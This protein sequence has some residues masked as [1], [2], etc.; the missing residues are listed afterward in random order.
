MSV[1]TFETIANKLITPDMD[2]ELAMNALIGLRA[3]HQEPWRGYHTFEHPL[4]LFDLLDEFGDEVE[5]KL[6]VGW[7]FMY[8]DAVYDP[9]LAPGKGMSEE[10]SAQ[11]S[12]SEIPTFA[13]EALANKVASL[14]RA[15][16]NHRV[17]PDDYDANFF[18]DA[19]VAILGSTPE[20]YDTYVKGIEFE[21]FRDNDETYTL[22]ERLIGRMVI[23]IDLSAR[24]DNR[25]LF[26]TDVFRE[27]F[28]AQAQENI[29]RELATLKD[30]AEY[31]S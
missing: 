5:D 6:A 28:E 4:E 15:T 8:H 12:E 16:F 14:T 11:L 17:D 27:N 18:M 24:V 22:K 30:R 26:R 23:L 3:R 19:D 7:G 29:V 13:W 9:K 20:R 21:Y 2:G 31:T 25:S 1:N 10:R